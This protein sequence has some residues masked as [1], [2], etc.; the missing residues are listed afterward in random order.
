MPV[1]ARVWRGWKLRGADK[2]SRRDLLLFHTV[3][4]C[5]GKPA[6]EDRCNGLHTGLGATGYV[7]TRTY[8]GSSGT[9]E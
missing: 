7:G 3:F 6:I 8:T 2:V 5:E 1:T 9:G 4:W